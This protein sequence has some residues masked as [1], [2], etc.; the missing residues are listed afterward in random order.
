[1]PGLCHIWPEL[2]NPRLYG[3]PVAMGWRNAP[4][5]EADLNSQALYV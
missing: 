4:L 3:V 2:G 5:Q 1:V